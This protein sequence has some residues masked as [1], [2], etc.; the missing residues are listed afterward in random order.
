MNHTTPSENL[1]GI[2]LHHFPKWWKGKKINCV[3]LVKSA[4]LIIINILQSHKSEV[5]S[6]GLERSQQ[7]RA[8]AACAQDLGLIPSTHMVVYN[9]L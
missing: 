3:F 8:C 2:K 4:E 9:H 5:Y 6:A 1:K 7:V